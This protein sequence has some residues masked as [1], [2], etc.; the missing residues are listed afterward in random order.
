M[1]FAFTVIPVPPTTLNV[2]LVVI[3]PPPVR[4]APAVK[5]T[6]EWSMCSLATKPLKLSCTISESFVAN[7][8]SLANVPPPLNPVPAV[9]VTPS[10]VDI[11]VVLLTTLAPMS[12][13][14]FSAADNSFSV[15]NVPGALPTNAS[16][17]ASTYAVEAAL[18][19]PPLSPET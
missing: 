9:S 19:E 18:V 11:L 5:V 14:S 7:V 2:L 15:S 1:L 3:S 10:S 12:A 8:L 13:S 4:P 6:P 17:A 16:I